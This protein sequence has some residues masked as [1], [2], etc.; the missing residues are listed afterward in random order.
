MSH[1]CVFL[2]QFCVS[3]KKP[4]QL[5]LKT[6][7]IFKNWAKDL[8]KLNCFVCESIFAKHK[9]CCNLSFILVTQTKLIFSLGGFLQASYTLVVK[10]TKL[11]E[12]N[13][14]KGVIKQMAH[15]SYYPTVVVI[16]GFMTI[17][18]LPTQAFWKSVYSLK[19]FY[20]ALLPWQCNS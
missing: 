9:N 7:L 20:N 3:L 6:K 18:Q 16:K 14:S 2:S 15:C 5:L 10:W 19:L 11:R 4:S 12:F 13:T 17:Q 8:Y 1:F